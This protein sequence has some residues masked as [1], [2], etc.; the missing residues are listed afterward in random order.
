MT[1]FLVVLLLLV[2]PCLAAAQTPEQEV[3]VLERAW[4]DA[5][6][7]Y[8][9]AWFERVLADTF[10]NTSFQGVV[11][12]KAAAI[13]DVKNKA[14]QAMASYE[15]LKVRVHGDTAIATGITLIQ[16]TTN[17]KDSTG[18]YAWTDTWVKRGGQWQCV[19]SHASR[20]N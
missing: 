14:S 2:V 4:I 8:D 13:A 9:V 10:V 17:G 7:N 15:N 19:A 16:G 20:V 12:G 6:V 11:T 5:A 1:K 3:A 18:R